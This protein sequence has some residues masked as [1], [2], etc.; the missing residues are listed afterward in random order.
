M[1]VIGGLIILTLS[2]SLLLCKDQVFHGLG[3]FLV[4]QD[5]LSP[6]DI[7]HVVAGE[8]YRTDYAIDLYQQGLSKTIFFTGGTCKYHGYDHSEHGM[9][10]A[11]AR[12]V[13]QDALA[14]DSTPVKST[15]DEAVLLKKYIDE[16]Q[17][18]VKSIIVVSDP[19]HMRR[20]RWTYQRVLGQGIQ[21][22][23]APVP[24]EQ[25][26]LHEKWWEDSESKAYVISEYGKFVYYI[27]R[28]WLNWGPLERW[29]ASFDKE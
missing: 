18:P 29:L 25:T 4:V 28:Y 16:N 17:L 22:L 1:L 27:G 14:A 24:F 12:G 23:M 10:L 2:F 19:F 5:E 8:D 15:Y 13:S 3:N 9:Q 6:A 26:P 21:V 20:A 7:L 11:R